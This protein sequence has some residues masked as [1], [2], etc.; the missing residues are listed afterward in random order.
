MKFALLVEYDGGGF[1][2]WQVQPR[3]RTVQGELQTALGRLGG[4]ALTVIGAGRTDAGVHAEGMVAH[5][6]MDP[7]ED[8]PSWKLIEAVNALT[9]E[10]MV[11]RDI[12]SVTDDFH[13]RYSAVERSY[14]YRIVRRK[15]AIGRG[16][17]WQVWQPFNVGRMNESIGVLLGEHDFTSFSK[18]SED[19]SHYRCTVSE[20]RVD[21]SGDE[22]EIYLSANR[23]VRGMVRALVGALVEVGRGKLSRE[24]YETLVH[25]PKE[26]HRAKFICPP[27]GLTFTRVRYPEVFGLW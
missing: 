12:R 4:T 20:A 3:K 8:L 11:V 10:D 23:F 13:A 17:A 15:I 26:L 24:E 16:Y 25:E 19:V 1:S 22:I 6:E 18:L 27:Q 2:G 14:V 21:E 7:R 9:G 5:V